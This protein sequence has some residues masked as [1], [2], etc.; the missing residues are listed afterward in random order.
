MGSSISAIDTNTWVFNWTAPTIPVDSVT[1]Y[2]SFNA[3]NG[4][5]QTSGDVV[6]T[7]QK[8][9]FKNNFITAFQEQKERRKMFYYRSLVK[10]IHVNEGY[11]LPYN[12][13]AMDGR[14]VKQGILSN[15]IHTDELLQGCYVLVTPTNQGE[16]NLS[17][18]KFVVSE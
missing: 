13:L 16:N 12:I 7:C 18:Y 4:D 2:S 1:F 17:T 10:Q 5:G 11:G 15:T 8:T 3:A 14:V 6:Y 9:Y